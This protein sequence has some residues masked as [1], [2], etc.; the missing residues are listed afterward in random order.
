MV[1]G[2]TEATNEPFHAFHTDSTTPS[3]PSIFDSMPPS[4]RTILRLYLR[5]QKD[6]DQER[7]QELCRDYALDYQRARQEA[8]KG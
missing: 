2:H 4:K 7:A 1:L 5:G 3:P 8:N 6:S